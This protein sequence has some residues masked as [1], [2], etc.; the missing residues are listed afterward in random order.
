M[1]LDTFIEEYFVRPIQEASGYNIVN[2]V[3]YALLFIG[4]ITLIKYGLERAK[5][6]TDR[7]FF[8]SVFP[9]ILLGGVV[10]S[11]EDAQVLPRSLLTVTPGV[12]VLILAVS[13]FHIFLSKYVLSK[14]YGFTKALFWLNTATLVFFSLFLRPVYVLEFLFIIIMSYALFLLVAELNNRYKLVSLKSL[15]NKLM[16][17]AH[18]LDGFASFFAI[19]LFSLFNPGISYFE[20]HVVGSFIMNTFGAW[21]F[22]HVKIV[23]ALLA[24]YYIDKETDDQY[25][26]FVLKYFVVALGIRDLKH[27]SRQ[28]CS[29]QNFILLV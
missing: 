27:S 28:I 15:E 18:I 17:F 21:A 11:L 23:V 24:I 20:Q 12:Y 29:L 1:S 25:W 4:F 26:A 6:K 7:K 13:V 22:V 14:R 5:I 2:T 8:V 10:R 3:T 19:G 9:V 16:L